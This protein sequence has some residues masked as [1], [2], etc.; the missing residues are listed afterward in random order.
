VDESLNDVNQEHH[1]PE[2]ASH[3]NGH[4]QKPEHRKSESLAHLGFASSAVGRFQE[5]PLLR[6]E[7][8]QGASLLQFRFLLVCFFFYRLDNLEL[9][10]SLGF[11]SGNACFETVDPQKLTKRFAQRPSLSF[12][13]P[14]P[15]P[16]LFQARTP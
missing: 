15:A 13:P 16:S 2:P 6:P 1:K 8:T 12:E 14:K 5:L 4:D 3:A 7:R 10:I 11:K 9:S